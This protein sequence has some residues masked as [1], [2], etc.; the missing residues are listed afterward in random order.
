MI[1]CQHVSGFC[2]FDL[3][4]NINHIYNIFTLGKFTPTGTKQSYYLEFDSNAVVARSKSA[5]NIVTAQF[6]MQST[7]TS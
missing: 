4:D 7:T 2:F 6:Y 3:D 1:Q 5:S